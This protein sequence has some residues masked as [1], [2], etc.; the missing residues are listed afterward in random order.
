MD[1][2]TIIAEHVVEDYGAECSVSAVCCGAGALVMLV[3]LIRWVKDCLDIGFSYQD[4]AV[5]AVISLMF[6]ACCYLCVVFARQAVDDSTHV[7]YT[8][9]LDESVNYLE[10][11][12]RYEVLE[13]EDGIYRVREKEAGDER[14]G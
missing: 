6:L 1:G 11:A 13:D 8:V 4:V 10:F 5:T 12:E 7:E 3:F 14:E 9:T 2:V